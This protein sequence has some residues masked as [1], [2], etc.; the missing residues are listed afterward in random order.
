VE[1]D[2]LRAAMALDKKGRADELGF[3]LPTRLGH[4]EDGARRERT[5][6]RRTRA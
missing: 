6:K 5:R 4:V 1:W 3:I 2:D